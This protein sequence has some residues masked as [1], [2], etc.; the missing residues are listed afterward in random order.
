MGNAPFSLCKNLSQIIVESGN[1]HYTSVDGVLFNK[2]KTFLVQYPNGN[3][4]STYDV[5]SGVTTIGYSA[6]WGNSALISITLPAKLTTIEN[7]AFE[8]CSGLKSI[9]VKSKN[10]PA[11]DE[12]SFNG[13][14]LSEVTLYIPRDRERLMQRHPYG[15]SLS[16]SPRAPSTMHYC[17]SL[18][19]IQRMDGFICRS[20][21]QR[22]CVYIRSMACLPAH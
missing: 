4:R 20:H 5:P 18:A 7:S 9:I 11:V 22:R 8:D 2:A 1:T 3:E 6:F 10:P 19:Y 17:P 21:E 16:R 15:K 14:K 13:I 12:S